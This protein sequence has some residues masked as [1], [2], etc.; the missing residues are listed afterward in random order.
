MR[1]TS[2]TI[3][4]VGSQYCVFS[5]DGTKKFGCFPSEG[6]AKKRLSQIEH[7]KKSKGSNMAD[8]YGNIFSGLARSLHREAAGEPTPA[9][10][11]EVLGVRGTVAGQVSRHV[12]DNKDHFPVITESQAR[13][14]LARSMQLQEVPSW[15][16]SS[17][18]HMREEVYLG[19]IGAHP[20]LSGAVNVSVPLES[21][22]ALSD[23]QTE[24]EFT[25]PGSVDDPANV[26]LNE[27]TKVERPNL[28][29]QTQNP[30]DKLSDGHTPSANAKAV[31]G[32][33]MDMIAKKEAHLKVAKKVAQRLSKSGI[34]GDEFD[35]LISYLQED[36]LRE[37]MYNG[38]TAKTTV[39]DRREELLANLSSAR[40]LKTKV[41]DGQKWWWDEKAKKWKKMSAAKV[42]TK[43]DKNTGKAWIWDEHTQTWVPQANR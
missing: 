8:D 17:L 32:H 20:H 14:S 13:S 2:A 34:T 24:P 10:L 19:A 3:K 42:E 9:E 40:A 5:K 27:V 15:Y 29:S 23:G 35:K 21:A 25:D 16:N 4:K 43:Y 11:N 18:D 31:A 28:N 26:R 38:V 1:Q 33:L 22:M 36:I 7:F 41:V 37:L 12:T 39:A 6:A 30:G